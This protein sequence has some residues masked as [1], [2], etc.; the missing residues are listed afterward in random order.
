MP[1]GWNLL[2]GLIQTEGVLAR[3]FSL[4]NQQQPT[5]ETKIGI[6]LIQNEVGAVFNFR[7]VV[8]VWWMNSET[9]DIQFW[10]NSNKPTIPEMNAPIFNL[11]LMVP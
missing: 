7:I 5:N 9:E 8:A 2:V 1:I 3:E 11:Q 6:E 4:I 10:M